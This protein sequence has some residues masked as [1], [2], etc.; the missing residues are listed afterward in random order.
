MRLCSIHLDT[1]S[2]SSMSSL[3]RPN[4]ISPR[5]PLLPPCVIRGARGAGM[6]KCWL[7]PPPPPAVSQ[8]ISRL[9]SADGRAAPSNFP[10]TFFFYL[11]SGCPDS[12][13]VIWMTARSPNPISET[14][15]RTNTEPPRG[16]VVGAVSPQPLV[17]A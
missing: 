17:Q 15:V 2:T 1:G 3:H 7:N 9:I 5:A 14:P 13:D 12:A 16:L 4:Q 6:R 8:T 10:F 11:L